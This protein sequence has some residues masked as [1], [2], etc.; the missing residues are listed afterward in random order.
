MQAPGGP[1][2]PPSWGPGRKDGFGVAPGHL[3][4]VWF[5]IARGSLSEVYFP[6]V[7]R[8]VL[9]GL[10]FL[11]AAPGSEPLDDARDGRHTSRWYRPG[12]PAFTVE[13]VHREYRMTKEFVTDPMSDALLISGTFDPLLPDLK[14]YVQAEPHMRPGSDGNQGAVLPL[15]PPVLVARQADVWIAIVGPF[16]VATVGY[17]NS[18]D[19][20]VGLH[21]GD[22]ELFERY[23]A[24]GQGNVALGAEVGLKGGPFQIAIGFAEGRADAEEIAREALR[25]G[26]GSVREMFERAW[27]AQPDLPP[28]L[29]RVGGDGGQ[30]A[31]CSLAVLRSLEDKSRPGAFIAA[32]AAPWGESRHDG[33]QVYQLVWPRDVCHVAAA[34]VDAGDEAAGLRALSYLEST[35]RPDGSWAQNFD[36][37]G[38]PHW[39][40]LELD[41]TALPV[42]L[43]WRLV[44]AGAR[45][46]EDLYRGMVGRAAAFIARTGPLTPL[47]RWEDGGGISPSTLAVAVAALVVAAELAAGNGEESAASHLRAVADYWQDRVEE[48]CYAPNGGFYVRLEPDL[49]GPGPYAAP[50]MEFLELVRRGIRAP[51]HPCVA[52]S[53]KHVDAI[54]RTETPAGPAW[55]RYVADAYG[56]KEDG[57]PWGGGREGR[58]RAWP[59]LTG[60]RA[61]L[62]L[63]LVR[64]ARDL[65]LAMEAFAGPELLL[66]EQVWDGPEISAWGLSSGGPTGSARPLGWAHAEYLQLL[67]SIA[68]ARMSDV[69]EPARRRYV[70]SAAEE[71]AFVWSAAHAL[72]TF[73]SGRSVRVQLEQPS[74]VSWSGDGWASSSQAECRD[75]GLGL[76]FADLPTGIMRPG[77][78]ME[79]RVEPEDGSS[80]QVRQLTCRPHPD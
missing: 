14:L 4:R 29:A 68:G 50:G 65:V 69:V 71:P 17:L 7:D 74:R 56:E 10:R 61:H 31:R 6:S 3:S 2:A 54:L 42:L 32:P 53:L 18:S 12:I 79:W 15:A 52:A 34:L 39:T 46:S 64:P 28:N 62:E 30:L 77:A 55:H 44:E 21:D 38:V 48:W 49:D 22:G 66:P 76:Y 23:Q 27:M 80:P 16:G 59:L 78:T 41:E 40:G 5:T 51:D 13:T 1:G 58:G 75:T 43:A 33:D 73:L 67:A 36:V 60:E 72:E 24:A 70:E 47:D 25:K 8:P 35:Q 26:A 11:I 9:N 19:L 20:Y 57:S 45:D 63:A 37:A